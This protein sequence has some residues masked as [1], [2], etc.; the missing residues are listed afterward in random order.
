[1]LTND[2]MAEMLWQTPLVS[3]SHFDWAEDSMHHSL[4]VLSGLTLSGS[5]LFW[6]SLQTSAPNSCF[7]YNQGFSFMN[8][9]SVLCELDEDEDEK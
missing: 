3:E 2:I 8:T 9:D 4:F 1:M 7:K 5:E 6:A